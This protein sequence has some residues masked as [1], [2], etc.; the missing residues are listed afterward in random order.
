[1][2][3]LRRIVP[4]GKRPGRGLGAPGVIGGLFWFLAIAKPWGARGPLPVPFPVATTGATSA[5]TGH[6]LTR[7]AYD[8]AL[9][10][11]EVPDPA[12]QLWPA[13]YVVDFGLAGPVTIDPPAPATTPDASGSVPAT[14]RPSPESPFGPTEPVRLGGADNLVVLGVN[15]PDDV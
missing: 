4:P 6:G 9:F 13:G 5:P 12:W 15:N 11:Q 3:D 10:G 1:M 8:P 14:P 2:S 7:G